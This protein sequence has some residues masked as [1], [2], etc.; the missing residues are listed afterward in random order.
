MIWKTN[1][2]VKLLKRRSEDK[3]MA[4]KNVPFFARTQR[5][6]AYFDKDL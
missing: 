2:T 1:A 4:A 5:S 6:K 3:K